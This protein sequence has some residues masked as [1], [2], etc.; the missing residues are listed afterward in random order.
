[1]RLIPGENLDP[2][3]GYG[4]LMRLD[5]RSRRPGLAHEEIALWLGH[6][7]AERVGSAAAVESI[8]AALWA[9]ITI[10]AE[11]ALRNAAREA[12]SR[13]TLA[14]RLNA[15]ARQPFLL[16][17]RRTRLAAYAAALRARHR[18]PPAAAAPVPLTLLVPYHTWLAW[19]LAACEDGLVVRDWVQAML[20]EA[21]AGRR[22]WEAAA[23]E[24]AQTL[25]EWIAASAGAGS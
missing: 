15:A 1:M 13:A 16:P 10:E 8:P 11:R 18:P 3:D 20:E 5:G 9:T 17:T 6:A 4:G 23:A 12:Q 22:L 21:P 2:D 19:E 24:R 14:G 25:A 7:S